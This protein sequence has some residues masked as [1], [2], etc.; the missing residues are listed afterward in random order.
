MVH[1]N[2][3][4]ISRILIY[5]FGITCFFQAKFLKI[6][7]FY[8]Q[9]ALNRVF[10]LWFLF[11]IAISAIVAK[12]IIIPEEFFYKFVLIWIVWQSINFVQG[13][14]NNFSGWIRLSWLITIFL[15]CSFYLKKYIK[16]YQEFL[17]LLGYFQI[18]ILI[19]MFIGL[20]EHLTGHYIWTSNKE[21]YSTVAWFINKKYPCAMQENPNDFA[22]L[23]FIGVFISFAMLLISKSKLIKINSL[24]LILGGTYLIIVS[25]SRSTLLGLLIGGFCTL[26]SY[27][28]DRK[29]LTNK[30]FLTI[31]IV[32]FFCICFIFLKRT[33]I[34]ELINGRLVFD[35]SGG[36]SESV[37]W[38]LIKDGILA[39]VK[40]F[41]IGIGWH[42]TA[43][44][45][46]GIEVLAESG[47]IIFMG[48]VFFWISLIKGVNRIK[49]CHIKKEEQLIAHIFSG[50]LIGSMVSF[51]SP[52]SMLN[53]EWL[54]VVFGM[55]M[56]FV[57]ISNKEIKR[58][59]CHNEI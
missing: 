14:I 20:Y 34:F 18:G 32:G 41:G 21:L 44:H 35:F 16:C 48:Y 56:V 42:G 24:I 39:A 57:S 33:Y 36:N 12:R 17:N 26:L 27:F 15:A 29:P 40:S 13:A 22:V 51:I 23:M 49:K 59:V 6:H 47:I 37:R 31:I 2:T 4:K 46:Y 25:D 3:D 53:L 28:Y 50:M 58:E 54:G 43:W 55:F 1:L 19:Q 9:I 38:S 7:L 45:N 11:D 30:K 52:A 5:I 10:I 8:I